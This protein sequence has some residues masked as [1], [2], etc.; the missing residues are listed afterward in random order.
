MSWWW[1]WLKSKSS[2]ESSTAIERSGGPSLGG[3]PG[4]GAS[5]SSQATLKARLKGRAEKGESTSSSQ[6]SSALKRYLDRQKLGS[7]TDTSALSATPGNAGGVR[8]PPLVQPAQD[9]SSGQGPSRLGRRPVSSSQDGQPQASRSSTKPGSSSDPWGD[10]LAATA[11]SAA[12]DPASH[13]EPGAAAEATSGH[14][15]A[16]STR[17]PQPE[18]RWERADV[19]SRLLAQ[20]LD[21]VVVLIVIALSSAILGQSL[22]GVLANLLPFG[23]VL[24]EQGLEGASEQAGQ[25]LAWNVLLILGLILYAGWSIQ[26]RAATIGKRALGLEL[27]LIGGAGSVGFSRAALRE[28]VGKWLPVLALPLFWVLQPQ[29]EPPSWVAV[30]GWVSIWQFFLLITLTVSGEERLAAQDRLFGTQVMRRILI[31]PPPTIP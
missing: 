9:A 10:I 25:D 27:R 3:T 18:I 2:A 12:A 4:E 21:T 22:G 5:A 15:P 29:V 19:G 7:I 24:L 11:N 6:G 28:V 20:I 1:P 16:Q 14:K 13:P 8:S 23:E 30:L 26:E 31:S 17:P